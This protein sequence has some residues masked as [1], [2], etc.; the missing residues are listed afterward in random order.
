MRTVQPRFVEIVNTSDRPR[1]LRDPALGAYPD[2]R[3]TLAA[4][5]KRRVPVATFLR[6][7]HLPYLMRAE[8]YEAMVKGQ[9]TRRK[10]RPSADERGNGGDDR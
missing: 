8:R 2:D 5:E 7:Q 3:M 6:L 4:K 1:E 10:E 9:A